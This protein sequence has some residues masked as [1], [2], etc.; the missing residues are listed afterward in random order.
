MVSTEYD[1]PDNKKIDEYED[2]DIDDEDLPR[3]GPVKK[4]KNDTETVVYEDVE[5]VKKNG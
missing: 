1:E 5:L 2:I 3:I 4:E